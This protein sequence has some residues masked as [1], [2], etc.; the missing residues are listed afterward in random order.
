MNHGRRMMAFQTMHAP[1]D[2]DPAGARTD[3]RTEAMTRIKLRLLAEG[4]RV[5]AGADLGSKPALRVRSG[6]CGGLDLILPD[7]TWVNAPVDEAFARRSELRLVAATAGPV[8]IVD[9]DRIPVRLVSEPAYYRAQ[10]SS[11]KPM[12]RVGQLCSDRVGIGI[13]N[14]C[15]FYRSAASRCRFCSIGLN[16]TVEQGNK[17]D[18]DVIET[19]AA[20]ID[21]PVAPA[22]HIL[23]GG[24]TP[25]PRDTGARRIAGL[26]RLIKRRGLTSRSTR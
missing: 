1:P 6:S 22:R 3:R 9:R 23:L 5:E 12:S 24:G 10:T 13:T 25:D 16:T 26:A 7:G 19:I 18:V 20:A 15:T 11:G 21:D 2:A 4:L 14:A 8:L 17:A